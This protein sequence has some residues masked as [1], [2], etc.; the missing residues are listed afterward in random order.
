MTKSEG[1]V[2]SWAFQKMDWD[3]DDQSTDYSSR[4]ELAGDTAK[5][6]S[7]NVTNTI[8]GGATQCKNCPRGTDLNGCVHIVMA[9]VLPARL[10]RGR[11]KSRLKVSN[12]RW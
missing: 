12:S 10:A 3:D 1:V 4:F 8:D 6:Y 9:D 2:F 11:R 7:V 5:I